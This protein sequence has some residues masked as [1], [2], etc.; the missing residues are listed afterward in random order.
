MRA[1]NKNTNFVWKTLINTTVRHRPFANR[2]SDPNSAAFVTTDF[3]CSNQLPEVP[4][5]RCYEKLV[6]QTLVS[7][8]NSATPR[9]LCSRPF[10]VKTRQAGLLCAIRDHEAVGR[11]VTGKRGTEVWNL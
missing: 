5:R 6:K 1:E 3:H 9:T 10:P 8:A 2:C 11:I 4:R 7:Q